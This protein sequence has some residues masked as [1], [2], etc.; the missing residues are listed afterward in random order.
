MAVKENKYICKTCKYY[1]SEKCPMFKSTGE[2]EVYDSDINR[3]CWTDDNEVEL[4]EKEKQDIAGDIE[5]HR[6]F[7]EDL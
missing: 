4:T 6:K 7:V 5:M 2:Y 1:T 3:D